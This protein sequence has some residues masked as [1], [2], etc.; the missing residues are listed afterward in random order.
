MDVGSIVNE[1][2]GVLPRALD[3]AGH[4]RLVAAVATRDAPADRGRARPT[5]AD[6][7]VA[8]RIARHPGG[9]AGWQVCRCGAGVVGA[10]CR[11]AHAD[12]PP[13]RVRTLRRHR[14]GRLSYEKL[15]FNH[16][17]LLPKSL[18]TGNLSGP[19]T[20]GAY[21]IRHVDGPRPWVVWVHG[22]GQGQPMDLFFS[23]AGR[24]HHDLGFNV[25]L[26]VQPGHGFRRTA[27]PTYPDR[28]PLANVA[29]MMR[30]VSEVRALMRWLQPQ[31]TSIA[32]SG[33]SMGSP[34]AA[35]VSA[36][37]KDVDAV[38]VYTPIL[39]LNAMI[40]H[41]LARGG[42]ASERFRPLLQSDDV[43]VMTS[44]IDPLSVEPL[45]PAAPPAGGG[46]MERP[47]GVARACD[48]ISPTL[49]R[50]TV[51]VRRQ[52]RRAHLLPPDSGGHRRVPRRRAHG[53][54]A[55]R[56]TGSAAACRL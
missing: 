56:L 26:P 5:G 33:V 21:L 49:E 2:R 45:V 22:A 16:D 39:A 20:A 48:C 40:A 43:T 35:L 6:R 12:P 32:V 10:R 9:A 46:C 19:A 44:V 11:R 31:S 1:F 53:V 50:P 15:K 17:P 14:I 30:S 3:G 51:L 7:D 52:P 47:N 18:A 8:H 55:V 34:V 28:E 42:P 54:I 29:G 4:H 13:L 24:L 38:A 37:E 36:L 27:W 25:A 41:H 23:R